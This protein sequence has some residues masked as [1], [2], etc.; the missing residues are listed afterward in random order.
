MSTARNSFA[1]AGD[2]TAA[3]GAGGYVV[4]TTEEWNFGVY[5]Y[6]AAAWASGGNLPAWIS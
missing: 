4:T 5:S 6:T 3:L 1:S 2:Q